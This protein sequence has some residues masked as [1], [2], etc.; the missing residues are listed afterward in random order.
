MENRQITREDVFISATEP[1]LYNGCE[2]RPYWIGALGCVIMAACL[3][4]ALPIPYCLYAMGG[5]VGIW[6]GTVWALRSM[7]KSDP[8]KSEVYFRHLRW[9]DYLP[10]LGKLLKNRRRNRLV[11]K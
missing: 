1:I 6:G 3:F 11:K 10:P 7:A 9:P 5:V 2:Y 4:A 8:L